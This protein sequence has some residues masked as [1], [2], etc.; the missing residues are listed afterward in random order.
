M[1]DTSEAPGIAALIPFR[2]PPL[3]PSYPQVV[4]GRP[5]SPLPPIPPS[6]VVPHRHAHQPKPGGPVRPLCLPQGLA[7]GQ[8]RCVEQVWRVC[9]GVGGTKGTNLSTPLRILNVAMVEA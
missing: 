4:I 6:Q 8:P 7:V 1:S 5:P 9:M 3:P 2:Q